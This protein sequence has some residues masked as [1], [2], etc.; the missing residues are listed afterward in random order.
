M[1]DL[2]VRKFA[3]MAGISHTAIHRYK[4]G[5]RTPRLEVA[6]KIEKITE[7]EVRVKDLCPAYH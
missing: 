5:E 4:N 6:L 2:S 1:N 7:G 3:A